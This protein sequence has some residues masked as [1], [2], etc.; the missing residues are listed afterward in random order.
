MSQT[1][2]ILKHLKR[3][4]LTPLQ[5]LQKYG[6]YRLAARINDLR[7]RG[8]QI[9]TKLKRRNGKEFASYSMEV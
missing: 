7:R 5:A 6:I 4:P 2:Q 8:Y 3:A 1:D 9:K